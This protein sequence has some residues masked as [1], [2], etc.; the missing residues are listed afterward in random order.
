MRGAL[1][2]PAH[3]ALAML[4]KAPA[5]APVAHAV[6]AALMLAAAAALHGRATKEIPHG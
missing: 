1:G 5:L 3:G 6:S 2:A 4:P